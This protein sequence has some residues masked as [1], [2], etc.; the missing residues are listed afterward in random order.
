MT[1]I[2]AEARAALWAYFVRERGRYSG[3]GFAPGPLFVSRE[4]KRMS[5]GAMADVLED[6]RRLARTDITSHQFR[7]YTAA[8]LLRQGAHLDTV[9]GQLGHEGAQMSLTYGREGRAERNIREFH[10][11]DAG[12]R[13]IGR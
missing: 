7:R 12:V 6:L 11:L 8:R 10:A 3:S 2:G 13:R 5:A 1:A 9:M 4:G